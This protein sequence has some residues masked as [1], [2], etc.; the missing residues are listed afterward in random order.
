MLTLDDLVRRPSRILTSFLIA[1]GVAAYAP[2]CSAQGLTITEIPLPTASSTPSRVVPGPDGAMWFTEFAGNRIGRITTSG[3]IT[4]FN[5][6]T[7]SS[8]PTGIAAGPDGAMWFTEQTGNKIGRLTTAGAFTEVPLPIAAST[9]LQIIAGPDGAMWFTEQSGNKIG[10][11]SMNGTIT[12]FAIPTVGGTPN[13]LTLGIDGNLWFTE[14]TASK[15]GRLTLAGVFT[16]FPLNGSVNP[17]TIVAGPDGNLWFVERG[18]GKIGRITT[19]GTIT[20]FTILTPS[21]Q[22]GAITNGPDGAL[23]IADGPGNKILRMTTTGVVTEY[24]V[25]TANSSP[26]GI[27]TGPDGNLWFTESSGNKIG[28]GVTT[29]VGGTLL[30]NF[31]HVVAEGGWN[32]RTVLTNLGNTVAQTHLKF[33]GDGGGALAIPA[34]ASNTGVPS[35]ASWL[36]PTLAPNAVLQFDSAGTGLAT[37][38]SGS[39]Q[40]WGDAGAAGFGIFSFPAFKWDAV[41]PL[42]TR[43]APDYTLAFDNTG[44]LATGLAVS[45]ISDQA[46]TVNVIIRDDAGAQIATATIN[47]PARGHA[48]FML[49]DQY[50]ATANRRGTVQFQTP[51]G[52]QISVIGLRANGPALTTLPVLANVGTTGGSITH[53]TYNGG[54]TS[55]FFLVNTGSAAALFNLAFFDESG[56]PLN[57]PLSLPQTGTN[58]TTS[59]LARTLSAGAMMVVETVANDSAASISG[60]AQLSASGNVSGFEIFRWT[61]F[62][63]EASVPLETRAPGSYLLVFDNTNGLTTG[64]ALANAASSGATITVRTFDKNGN[65]LRTDTITLPALGHTSFLLPGTFPATADTVG[66]VEFV[67]PQGGKI[68]A[69]GLRA[70]AD[71]TLTTIPILAKEGLVK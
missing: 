24:A 9:P 48:S 60:S 41:V 47:L 16:E 22:L 25:P 56:A 12:E 65:L 46:A 70:K 27:I 35:V 5:V 61:T 18:P 45:N 58:T 51:G 26:N 28:K 57:V 13:G 68:N 3:V 43:N 59:A 52:G 55:I 21:V 64:V 15:V 1:A 54:F 66:T 23:W 40:L 69:I 42:E 2:L 71:G 34:L 30:G 63:Q 62:G 10:R 14:Q 17:I 6:P 37:T 29:F 44:S 49:K 7:A 36:D 33:F 20:E 19:S 11:I 67:V 50:P 53:V 8:T 4:E 39:A 32:T 38:Q 31:A